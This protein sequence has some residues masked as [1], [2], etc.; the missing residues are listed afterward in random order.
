M[1]PRLAGKIPNEFTLL[2]SNDGNAA[3]VN[4]R[5]V[6]VNEISPGSF[7]ALLF[8]GVRWIATRSNS[9]PPLANGTSIDALSAY[10]THDFHGFC[11]S[12]SVSFISEAA[13]VETLVRTAT[14]VGLS[15]YEPKTFD[16]K[17]AD[18]SRPISTGLLTCA[19]CD[20]V[21][22]NCYNSGTCNAK[23]ECDCLKGSFG[24][25]CQMLAQCQSLTVNFGEKV[26]EDQGI[27]LGE[28]SSDFFL[29]G[30]TRSYRPV[31]TS[32]N[33]VL[34]YCDKL[35]AWT[36][37]LWDKD[38]KK[39]PELQDPCA[40][41]RAIITSSNTFDVMSLSNWFTLGADG[42]TQVPLSFLTFTC[43]YNRAG[44]EVANG[45]ASSLPAAPIDW[46]DR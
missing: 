1:P 27:V 34:A 26:G 40:R 9:H 31:Y 33:G 37:T 7:L 38:K 23:G 32:Q 15:W 18:V 14:P 45:G 44:G 3:R 46:G 39:N 10:L 20:G 5:P 29:S 28:F 6:Y 2:L 22:Y 41:F 21:D 35:V 36:F 11:S 43:N 25:S 12:Y 8:T 16:D 17:Q 13:D 24:R 4:Y 19:Y 42:I 30:V